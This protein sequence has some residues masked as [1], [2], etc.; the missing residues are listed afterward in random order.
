MSDF[1]DIYRKIGSAIKD[2]NMIEE[3]DKILVALSGGKDS[4]TMLD[5]LRGLQKRAPVKFSL[6]ACTV[7]PGFPGFSTDKIALW[8]TENNYD[9]HVEESNIYQSVFQDKEKISD[10]CFYCARQRRSVLYR[11]ADSYGC[12][13]I[14]MGHHRDDF[15]ETVLLSM[16]YNGKIET[17][18]PVF[19]AGSK[20]FK[21]IRPLIYVEEDRIKV[22]SREKSFPVTYCACPL[23]NTGNL[24]RKK[25]KKM[26]FEFEK[27]DPKIKGCLFRSLSNYNAEYMLDLRYNNGLRELIE[28]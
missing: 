21:I 15:I 11:Q 1:K 12:N 18:L 2:Y 27:N 23:C 5:I 17:M 24:R 22:Y 6:F 8:L 20:K 3:G 25:V 13:K 28:K 4:F 10:G 7:H 26:L 9:F 16:M 14:A 19:E